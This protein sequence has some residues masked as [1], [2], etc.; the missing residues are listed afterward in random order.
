[1][2]EKTIN[3]RSR[4]YDKLENQRETD[5]WR[6]RGKAIN[7]RMEERERERESESGKQENER[8]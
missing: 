4:D 8:K 1:M 7:V 3:G 5:K 6:M 2:K